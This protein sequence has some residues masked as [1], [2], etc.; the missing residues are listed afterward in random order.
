MFLS[1]VVPVYNSETILPELIESLEK[2][3]P[4]LAKKYEVLLVNDG[5]HDR[6]WETIS[7]LSER[8]SWVR[9]F[10]MMRNYGQHNAL[11]C[12]M[13]YAQGDTMITMDDD[14]QHPPEEIHKLL[15][16]LAK[17]YDVV[18]GTPQK[19]QHGLWRDL[20][21]NM[22]K[23]ALQNTMGITAARNVG[24]F[25]AL[26]THVCNA[27]NNYHNPYVNID[28][29]LTWGT[30]KFSAVPVRHAPRLRGESSYTF[31][32]LMRHAINMTIGFNTLPLR[33]A[34]VLGFLLTLFGAG[35][36]IYVVGRY[37]LDPTKYPGFAFLASTIAIFSGAQLFALG[38]IGEYLARMYYSSMERPSFVVK[39]ITKK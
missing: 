16:E 7:S 25:R 15:M 23:M 32:K 2:V 4:T 12:G 20:A 13:Q 31:T 24:P 30:S 3:L 34:S 36:F 19:E 37:F 39:Q 5:S 29:L 6:S 1:V 38:I 8:Y 17:G 9:G 27:F 10:D 18:Y 28:V 33:F 26:R 35:V 11:L 21:S 14:L 22:T